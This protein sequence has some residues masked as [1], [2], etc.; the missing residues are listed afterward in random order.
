MPKAKK[1]PNDA[2]ERLIDLVRDN[3]CLYN[4]SVAEYRDLH[5]TNNVW[6]S[7]GDELSF[8]D[9]SGKLV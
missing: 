5:R 9:Y 1:I 2:I 8:E 3:E 7:I 6:K 4:A